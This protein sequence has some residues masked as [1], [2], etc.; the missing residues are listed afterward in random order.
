L[1]REL[2]EALLADPSVAEIR[3]T[4]LDAGV[5]E[6]QVRPLRRDD[7]GEWQSGPTPEGGA[8]I[9]RPAVPE[10]SAVEEWHGQGE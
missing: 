10:M 7:T 5:W 4:R 9:A 6:W 3:L 1:A 2:Y 8:V